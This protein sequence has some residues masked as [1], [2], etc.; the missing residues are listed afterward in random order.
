MSILTKS[1]APAD[2]SRYNNLLFGQIQGT[3][4]S[5]AM[6]NS[7]DQLRQAGATARAMLVAAA[8]A[9]WRVP[10]SEITVER[11]VVKHAASGRSAKFGALAAK[12]AAQPVPANVAL[13]DP[14]DFHLI[15]HRVSRLD[16]PAKTAKTSRG[17]RLR[18]N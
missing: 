14:K 11:G 16:T 17:F 2:A 6:A 15:G 13:K 12:A 1:P 7:W 8:A 9:E 3:G 10:A 5:T 4:G 18:R